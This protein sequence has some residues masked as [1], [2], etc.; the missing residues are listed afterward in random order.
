MH[1]LSDIFQVG[2]LWTTLLAYGLGYALSKKRMIG[3]QIGIA[4]LLLTHSFS[5]D[6]SLLG[7]VWTGGYI[8]GLL[9]QKIGIWYGIFGVLKRIREGL[10]DFSQ[11]QSGGGQS[12]QKTPQPQP[13]HS[14]SKPPPQQERQ[15]QSDQYQK[16]F[17]A[18]EKE[19][20]RQYQEQQRAQR[21]AERAAQQA[22]ARA[23]A[24]N[25]CR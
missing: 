12:Y 19:R 22:R 10:M 20:F 17:E 5:D 25:E 1:S 6:A 2:P 16:D 24:T 9:S 3:W 8:A 15:D 18:R 21:E 13:S 7:Q 23:K 14:Y 11:G 4:V